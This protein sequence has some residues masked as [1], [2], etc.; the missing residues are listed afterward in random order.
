MRRIP[1]LAGALLLAAC[2]STELASDLRTADQPCRDQKFPDKTALV[3]CL[4]SHERPVWARDEPK[5]L[6]LYDGFA[7][8]RS[9]LARRFDQKTISEPQY[10]DQL[11]QTEDSFRD[12]INAVRKQQASGGD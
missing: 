8:K 10:R 3:D 1:F 5:T 7:V 9:D 12:Q 11:E 4:A 6:P 2:S